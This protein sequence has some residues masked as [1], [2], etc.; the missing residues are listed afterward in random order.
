MKEENTAEKEYSV[1][2]S[3]WKQVFQIL[4]KISVFEY[5]KKVPHFQENPYRF[6]EYWVMGHTFASFLFFLFAQYVHILPKW[7]VVL[8]F[9]YGFLR[10][11]EIIVYQVNVLFFDPYENQNYAVKSYRRMVILLLHNYAEIIFWFAASYLWISAIFPSFLPKGATST[12]FGTFM[13]SFLTMVGF[14]SNSI[15]SET[16]SSI[17]YWHSVLLFQAVIGLFMTMIC[18]ARFIGLLPAPKSMS[19]D[20][21]PEEE[22]LA[23]EVIEIKEK[24]EELTFYV[25]ELEWKL[26]EEEIKSHR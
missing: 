20:E 19:K 3:F 25:K 16:L 21:M 17:N 15:S 7:T 8:F 14:G 5:V 4:R 11:F 1:V 9:A 2:I 24:L 26:E 10:V 12:L 23:K 13:Y 6:V 22:H 18:L